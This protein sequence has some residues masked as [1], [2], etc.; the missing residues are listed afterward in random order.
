ML[1][2][3][4]RTISYLP[5]TFTISMRLTFLFFFLLFLSCTSPKPEID[6]IDIPAFLLGEFEDDYGVIYTISDSILTMEDHTM[7]HISEWNIKEQYFVGQNDSLNPYDPLLFT[8]IDWMKFENMAPFE[9]GFCMSAYNAPS[10]D[11]AKI[12]PTANRE[13][14]KTGCGGYPFSRMK[15]LSN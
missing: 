8:R 1:G 7:L 5:K 14:P 9:W 4:L 13:I 11:S 10:L 6:S 12:V 2:I 3:F 15:S